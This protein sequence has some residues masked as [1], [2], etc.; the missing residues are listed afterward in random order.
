MSIFVKCQKETSKYSKNYGE[1]VSYLDPSYK[2]LD[3]V[4]LVYIG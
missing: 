3:G 1:L 2:C 4:N